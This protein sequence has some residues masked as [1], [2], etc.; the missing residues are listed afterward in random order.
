[1]DDRIRKSTG[2]DSR[3]DSA[4]ETVLGRL[5]TGDMYSSVGDHAQALS[6]YLG[7]WHRASSDLVLSIARR[8]AYCQSHLG[9]HSEVVAF[10]APILADHTEPELLDNDERVELGRCLTELGNAHFALGQLA[11]AQEAGLA[12]LSCLRHGPSEH[13]GTA[14]NLLG[15]IVLHGGEIDL[16]RTH[17]RSALRYFRS[18]G[19]VTNLAFAY[20]NLGH[21]HKRGCEWQ[22]ALE[23][24]QAAYYLLATEGEFQDRSALHHNL[25][26][27]LLMVGRF[28]EAREQL[29]AAL[30]SAAE[31]GNSARAFRSHL[32]MVRWYR[33]I[34]DLKSA[35]AELSRCR[36]GLTDA[37]GKRERFLLSLAEAH[38]QVQQGEH[39]FVRGRLEELRNEAGS[40]SPGMVV[41][42]QLLHAE[43]ALDE[44]SW[45]EA[46]GLIDEARRTSRERKDR[47]QE[48]RARCLEMR[49]LFG[50]GRVE[51]AEKVFEEQ[52][53]RTSIHG[54]RP[55]EAQLRFHR[56]Q[57][58]M[59]SG[60][61][62]VAFAQFESA[63]ELWQRMGFP[64]RAESIELGSIRCL[65]ESGRMAE[66][67]ARFEAI[68]DRV[69]QMAP[70]VVAESQA[71]AERLEAHLLAEPE[72]GIDGARVLRRLEEIFSWDA[73]PSEMVR[74]SVILLAEALRAEGAILGRVPLDPQ[75]ALDV[76]TSVS[77][78]RLGGRRSVE[79][80]VLGLTDTTVARTF[81]L[82]SEG[83]RIGA[84]AVP[85]RIHGVPHL[86]YLE[87]RT[88]DRRRF[89][90]VELDY[91]T[92]LAEQIAR[93]VPR[94][95]PEPVQD[96][97]TAME[98]LRHGIY[99]A[100]IITQD[101]QMLGILDLVR[102][103]SASDLSVLLQGETG[104]GKKLVAQAIHR[105]SPRRDRPLVTVD[106]AALPDTLLESELFGHRK[107]AFTGAMSDRIGLLEE[108][109]GGTIFLDEI[110]KAGL[111]VQRRFLHM[112]DS[113]EIRPVGDTGYR[114]LD[115]RVVCATSCPDLRTEVEEGRFIKDLYYRLNDIA[116]QIPA[117]R[118][119]PEDILLLTECFLDRFAQELGR[120]IREV[121][122]T[123]HDAIRNHDWPGNVRE[124][125]KAVRRAVTLAEDDSVL[126]PE[127]LPRAVLEAETVGDSSG[128]LKDQ[129]EAMEKDILLQALRR[130][131]W[132]KSRTANELGLSRKGLKGKLER[133]QLDRRRSR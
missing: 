99:V 119:R 15:G 21:V 33:E 29:D 52:L 12:S 22:R 93:S 20:N 59:S 40:V 103:V 2:S 92:V 115:V 16:A 46:V 102:R 18:A 50:L 87:R 75:A 125:E 24:Y 68:R 61:S 55:R 104:T 123:F 4:R 108:A 127:H 95:S 80:D 57:A 26:I 110:D 98:A 42:T 107:G 32:A 39:E 90:R 132:N 58:A 48:N 72:L 83:E 51:Q 13:L 97:A 34:G 27:A 105:I 8:V 47:E 86:F 28:S 67:A 118:E 122:P 31:L 96:E 88:G 43:I 60:D 111:A 71:I 126:G 45:D 5:A 81:E 128:S 35:G 77:M 44:S 49:L 85:A 17:F 19:D 25:G 91:A 79:A 9:R 66:A 76:V 73:Q 62:K 54:E 129:L 109:N 14:E 74:A 70:R 38:L 131:R 116:I 10:L 130:N 112:L 69:A 41:E 113:G 133:F 106:C 1:M 121:S 120:A 53:G 65:I 64:Q 124:L 3:A 78:G 11:E 36:S 94:T 117:L 7:V 23:H 63:R 100:D 114:S 101:P 6:T 89:G 30:R 84:L 82:S 37:V 56:A